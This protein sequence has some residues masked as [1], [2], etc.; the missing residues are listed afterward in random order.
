MVWLSLCPV[1]WLLPSRG[2]CRYGSLC[3]HV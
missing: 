2:P 1:F 3:G